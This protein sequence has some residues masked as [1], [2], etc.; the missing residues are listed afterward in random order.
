MICENCNSVISVKYGSG[1]F[2]C[3]KCARAF[4]TK[5]KR[6][7]INKKVSEKLTGKSKTPQQ[8]QSLKDAWVK[9]R[10]ERKDNVKINRLTDSEFFVLNSKNNNQKIKNRLFES[11]IKEYRCEEC[12]I[13][14]YN[15]KPIT[16]HLHHINGNKKDNRLEN[17]QILCP[18]CH[19]QTDNY[20]GKDLKYGQK[21]YL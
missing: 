10:L 14:E 6:E 16:L 9:R 1:R 21:K 19:S 15:N 4:S 8:I 5:N 7:Q 2:C 18:N 3:I 11:K 12:D 13:T 17:L 20:A